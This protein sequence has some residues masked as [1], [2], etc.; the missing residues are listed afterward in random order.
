MIA[1]QGNQ[2][3]LEAVQIMLSI[4]MAPMDTPLWID[5]CFV[6]HSSDGLIDVVH[7]ST[8]ITIS[9]NNFIQHDK[10]SRLSD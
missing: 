10:L 1:R 5:H 9:N 7:G 4:A 8:A 2:D 3:L 6:A